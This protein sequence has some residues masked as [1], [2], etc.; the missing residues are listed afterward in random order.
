MGS[1]PRKRQKK[2]EKK[3]A[4]R[5]EKR[6]VQLRE[7]SAGLGDR[8]AAAAK[9]PILD[10]WVTDTVESE[11]LGWVIL[12]REIPNGT[13][14][15]ANFLVDRYCLGVKNVH[16]E[17][18]GRASYDHKYARRMRSELPSKAVAPADARKLLEEAAAYARKL[19]FAPHPD[20]LKALT[21][22]GAVNAA[23]STATYEFG[24][25]GQPFYV[26]GPNDTPERS[27]QIITIL[28]NSCGPG[29]F[30]YMVGMSGS[31]MLPIGPDDEETDDE[32]ED[33]SPE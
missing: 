23:D 31:D 21:L 11:G 32:E 5:K 2:L 6:H 16:A 14:A 17:I 27:R 25:D 8:L 19:G 29:N 24:K 3:T 33:E 30:H 12:S 18:L 10:S 13:V 26:S 4:K 28:T 7:Q 1:D 22:F 15:V 9:F 20:Y